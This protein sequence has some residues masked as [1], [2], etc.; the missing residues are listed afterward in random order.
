MAA[1]GVI[2]GTPI[3][4]GTSVFTV[5]IADSGG[6]TNNK[7]LSITVSVP[8][9]LVVTSASLPNGSVKG[10]YSEALTASGGIQPY[11]WSITAGTLPAGLTL[12]GNTGA[13]TGKPTT[14]QTANFTVRAL[15]FVGVSATKALSITV[16]P[17][18]FPE[19]FDGNYR[20][21]AGNSNLRS[22]R[23][24]E[25]QGNAGRSAGFRGLYG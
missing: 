17:A 13:I 24:V 15:D 21:H 7:G 4:T 22:G 14:Q 2:S 1:T 10:A 16:G 9:S 12:N 20:H 23:D 6:Q 25:R 8:V 5:H 19:H 11:T 3:G 18:N